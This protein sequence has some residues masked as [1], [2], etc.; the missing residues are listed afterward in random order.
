MWHQFGEEDVCTLPKLKS[1]T[2]YFFK[3]PFVGYA[4]HN[5][6]MEIE[7]QERIDWQLIKKYLI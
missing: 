1:N 7:R 5:F 6:R 2:L 3:V 4:W